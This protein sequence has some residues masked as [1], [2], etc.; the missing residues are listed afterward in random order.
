MKTKPVFLVATIV[1]AMSF[2]ACQKEIS[3]SSVTPGISM[4]PVSSERGIL[5]FKDKETMNKTIQ[6]LQQKSIV[7]VTQWEKNLNFTSQFSVF[8]EVTNQE[9][10]HEEKCIKSG[11]KSVEHSDYYFTIIKEN[12][13]KEVTY[14]DGTTSYDYNIFDASVVNVINKEGLVVI[15]NVLHQY[16][17][18]K[19][20]TTPYNGNASIIAIK[21]ASKTNEH[22]TV[23][24]YSLVRDS[25]N[26]TTA[27]S[28]YWSLNTNWKTA[29][30]LRARMHTDGYSNSSGYS[31]NTIVWQVN[32]DFQKKNFWGN[33]VYNDFTCCALTG[34]WQYRYGVSRNSTPFTC[35]TYYRMNPF[36]TTPITYTYSNYWPSINKLTVK[37]EPNGTWF[38]SSGGYDTF[39]DAVNVYTYS[40][41]ANLC[42][43]SGALTLSR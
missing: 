14:E 10:L 11:E 19:L 22:V 27:S 9:N 30:K 40:F 25:K 7:D 31:S 37:L 2:T 38:A 26:P 13:L 42:A 20:K 24:E 41:S 4:A 8:N 23:T 12:I 34:N 36:S 16:A 35:N 18:N 15:N 6:E 39:C 29:G 3:N 33:W 17:D 21:A 1:A 32:I 28:Y 5:K 43:I